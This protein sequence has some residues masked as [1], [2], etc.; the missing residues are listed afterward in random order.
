M[1]PFRGSN[2]SLSANTHSGLLPLTF[3]SLWRETNERPLARS[4][5]E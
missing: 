2:P 4:A 3:R 1:H 5:P